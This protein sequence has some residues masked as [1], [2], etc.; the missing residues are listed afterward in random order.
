MIFIYRKRKEG[1]SRPHTP[2][3]SQ[4]VPGT[5]DKFVDEFSQS[6]A[7]KARAAK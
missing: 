7:K 5:H 2:L 4:E 6:Q 1:I 3:R